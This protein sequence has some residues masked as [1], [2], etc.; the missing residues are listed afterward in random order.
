MNAPY[1]ELV[2]PCVALCFLR[3]PG[4]LD[5]IAGCIAISNPRM[6]SSKKRVH[7][8]ASKRVRYRSTSFCAANAT[9]LRM[10]A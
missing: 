4:V 5:N 8:A 1:H 10:R 3:D 6:A 7:S 9:A 2:L